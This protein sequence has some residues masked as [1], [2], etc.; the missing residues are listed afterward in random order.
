MLENVQRFKNS[1]I[2]LD[3]GWCYH[4]TIAFTLCWIYF[5]NYNLH[6]IG[7]I[8]KG[9]IIVLSFIPVFTMGQKLYPSHPYTSVI[10]KIYF[11][12]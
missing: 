2:F 7:C 5:I 6:T 12:G 3:G 8:L 11:Q 4:I 10:L 1:F 9:D